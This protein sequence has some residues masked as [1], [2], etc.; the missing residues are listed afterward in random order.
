MAKQHDLSDHVIGLY[1]LRVGIRRRLGQG[2]S[3]T[4]GLNHE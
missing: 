4:L 2:L 1:S 3:Q